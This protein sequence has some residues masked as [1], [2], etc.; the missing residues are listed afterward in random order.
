MKTRFTANKLASLGKQQLYSLARNLELDGRAQLSRTELIKILTYLLV[1]PAASSSL[2][3]LKLPFPAVSARPKA[4]SVEP[5]AVEKPRRGRP[6]KAAPVEPVAVDK[7]RRGRPPKAAPVEPVAV[8]KPRRGRPPKAAPVE[9]VAVEK[10][11]RGRPPKTGGADKTVSAEAAGKQ[12]EEEI[13]A[14]KHLSRAF[15]KR[16]SDLPANEKKKGAEVLEAAVAIPVNLPVGVEEKRSSGRAE[17]IELER[18]RK[19]SSLKT[20]M[21]IPVFSAPVYAASSAVNEADL[22]GDLPEYY[23]ETR[24]SLQVRDPHW[25][26]AYWELPPVERKRLELEVGIF[27]FAH[28]YFVLR[29]HNVTKGYTS[30]IRLVEDARNWY[31]NCEHAQ[32]V[33][34][35]ELGLQSPT[36]GYT[37]I[38]LSNLVQTPADRVSEN[39]ATPVPPATPEIVQNLGQADRGQPAESARVAT[40]PPTAHLTDPACVY[41]NS[42]AAVPVIHGGSSELPIERLQTTAAMPRSQKNPV[43]PAGDSSHALPFSSPSSDQL[44]APGSSPAGAFSPPSSESL[45][46]ANLPARPVEQ[47]D[48]SISVDLLVYGRVPAGCRLYFMGQPVES[49]ADGSFTLRLALPENAASS[50]ELTAEDVASGQQKK[51]Q[52]SFV[53]NKK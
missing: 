23:D 44:Q 52:A 16:N 1:E 33:Y 42:P 46:S 49:G 45:S 12:C 28:S 18:R 41:L 43:I 34:Q 17:Q 30:E 38:A 19:H 2:R 7:P 24:I 22:T 27:E 31:I 9:L 25:L 35:V 3:S 36:E 20:T 40:E 21:E 51:I 29:L 8:E 48:I 39:W 50:L 47:P 15:A 6:P 4:A 32:C 37:F 5:V 14:L 13:A 26:Y 11:R 53:F 10:P